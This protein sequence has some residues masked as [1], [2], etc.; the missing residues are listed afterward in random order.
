[1]AFRGRSPRFVLS[2]EKWIWTEVYGSGEGWRCC[3]MYE[4]D[5]SA[6]AATSGKSQAEFIQ[7]IL[8]LVKPNAMP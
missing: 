4:I 6:P 7:A 5:V 3:L 2:P 8:A 1:M